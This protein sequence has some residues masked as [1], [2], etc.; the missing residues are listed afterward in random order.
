V[1]EPQ[2]FQLS[3]AYF[4][5]LVDHQKRASANAGVIARTSDITPTQIAE[6][7]RLAPLPPPLSGGDMP[8]AV[9]LFRGETVEF[10]LA[11]AQYNDVGTPQVLYIVTPMAALRQLG[12][13]VLALRALGMS[14]MP[15]FSAIKSNLVPYELRD[16]KPPSAEEQADALLNALLYCND[17]FSNLEGILA[18]LVQGWPLAIVNSPPSLEKRLQFLQGLLCLLPIP[19][20]IGITFAT[21]VTDPN[22]GQI[23]IKFMSQPALPPKH[24]VYDWGGGKLI[25]PAPEDSYSHF[26]VAQLRL[27]PSL[28]IEKT[29]QLSRTAVWRAMHRENLAKALAWVSRRAAIDQAVLNNQPADR[30]TVAAILREDPTLSDDLRLA[31]ARHLLAFAL[32]LN[33]PE[34]ADVIPAVAVTSP[35]IA[36]AIVDQLNT[37]AENDQAQIVFDLLERWLLR[38]P[39][40]SALQWHTHL[41]A[42]AKQSLKEWLIQDK[43]QEVIKFLN[44]A[45]K[46]NPTLR[47]NEVMPDLIRLS[48]GAARSQTRLAHAVFLIAVEVLPPGDLYRVLSDAQFQKQL[49]PELQNALSYLQPQPRKPVPPHILDQGARVF[50]DGRRMLVLT[51]LAEWAIYLQRTELIDT[52]ALQALLVL[53]QSEKS[54]R[55]HSLILHVVD[56][57]SE[58]SLVRAL[59][60]PGARVLVQLLLLIGEY[61]R[62]IGQ[63]VF[64]QSQVFGS[65]RIKEFTPLAGESFRLTPLAPEALNTALTF[66]E[67]SQIRPEPRAMIYCNALMNRQWAA[68]QQYAARQLTT[69]IFNDHHLIAT[70]GHEHILKLLDFYTKSHNTLDAL[71]VAAALVDHTLN[72][73]NEGATLLVRMYPSIT[74]NSEATEAALELLRRFVRGAPLGQV[75]TLLAYLEKELGKDTGRA[76]RATYLMRMVI[77][78]NEQA[79]P[80]SL[81][82]AQRKGISF[83][84]YEKMSQPALVQFASEVQTAVELFMDLAAIYHTDK[85]LPPPHRLRHDLDTLPGGLSETER[86][87]V[88]DN[89]LTIT[90]QV[91]ELGRARAARGVRASGV[92]QLVGGQVAPQSGL[93]LLRFVGGHFAR[94]QAIPLNLKREEMGHVLGTRSAAMLLRETNAIARLLGGLQAAVTQQDPSQI[95]APTLAAELNSLWGTLSLYNQRQIQ[96]T[97]ARSCQQLAE[98]VAIMTDGASDRVFSDGGIGRQLESGQKQPRTA[99][100]TLRWIQGY[101]ARKHTR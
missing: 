85:E 81:V 94:N 62:A 78:H 88:A 65:E 39:E 83:E 47:L 24:L 10:I 82:E 27:D 96:E 84:D 35:V 28:V 37:A 12:G 77:G 95:T 89:L 92:F 20:R 22:A 40:A 25:T 73:G 74:W 41:H 26:I 2:V 57:L 63:L 86:K 54:E 3:R 51:R 64:Y 9:G 48:V 18:G 101:F 34:S 90:R 1:P 60:P 53:A 61:D 87:Q 100:E 36:Q 23:Q 49:P 17:S 69:M 67:G 66:L 30:E 43:T 31:Y 75:P 8:G 14:D 32:A 59:E 93:D 91:Y 72:M 70:V 11:K 79:Q 21:N 7:V 33:E 45:H 15:A 52:A 16:P 55:F 5:H 13:N 29:A 97:F 76:L 6:C 58:L 50:G 19:A 38:V 99:L 80:M 4:G 42:A 46:A 44:R 71:R 98:V 68:D 56:E